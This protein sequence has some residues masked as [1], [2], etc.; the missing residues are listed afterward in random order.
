V[1]SNVSS[2]CFVPFIPTVG[3]RSIHAP[4]LHLHLFLTVWVTWGNIFIADIRANLIYHIKND[5]E[6]H[7][8]YP[9]PP[10][11]FCVGFLFTFS[12]VALKQYIINVELFFRL[13]SKLLPSSLL[14]LRSPVR[15]S[16]LLRDLQSPKHRYVFNAFS[17][18]L[19][20]PNNSVFTNVLLYWYLV[21]AFDGSIGFSVDQCI[22]ECVL[23][24]RVRFLWLNG[25]QSGGLKQS[26]FTHTCQ[27]CC[28]C[29]VH[30]TV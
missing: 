21:L 1:C 7:K 18:W 12:V 22:S 13:E 8:H 9:I 28:C 24:N 5:C 26:S 23:L 15:L 20:F 4:R 6:S 17:P 11:S 2:V 16:Q 27:G 10:Y 29:G 19:N 14:R 25:V 30:V 3:E